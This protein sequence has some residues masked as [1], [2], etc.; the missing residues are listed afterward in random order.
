[1]LLILEGNG[2]ENCVKEEVANPEGD[3]DNV[4]D[5]NNLVKSKR[6]ISISLST[7]ES[8]MYHP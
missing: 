7:I 3:K 5:K 8:H 1:M 6:I 4:K 2:L